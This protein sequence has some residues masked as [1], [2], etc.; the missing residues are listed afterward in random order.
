MSIIGYIAALCVIVEC[1]LGVLLLVYPKI[2]PL[3]RWSR[4]DV[5]LLVPLVILVLLWFLASHD[6]IHFATCSSGSGNGVGD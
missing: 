5:V 1:G 2:R 4:S 3:I 6:L